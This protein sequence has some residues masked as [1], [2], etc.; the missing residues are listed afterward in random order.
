MIAVDQSLALAGCDFAKA[1]GT[2]DGCA[3]GPN[4]GTFASALDQ[5]AVLPVVSHRSSLSDMAAI[6][7]GWAMLLLVVNYPEMQ[8]AALFS[9]AA[10]IAL[11]GCRR[12][13]VRFLRAC[14]G[15]SP[16]PTPPGLVWQPLPVSAMPHIAVAP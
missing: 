16:R 1:H 13:I 14:F 15:A 3:A 8:V 11:N 10:F 5:C 4:I 9:G 6:A 12:V 7:T 2:N